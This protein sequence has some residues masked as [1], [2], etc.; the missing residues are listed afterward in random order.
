MAKKLPA[1]NLWRERE[2]VDWNVTT[3]H[4]YL[5]EM[6]EARY[7][8]PKYIPFRNWSCEKG[9]LKRFMD[10][11]GN[12]IT[13]EFIDV[14]LRNYKEK[15]DYPT[16]TFGFAYS[17]MQNPHLTKI[18]QKKAQA[19]QVEDAQTKPTITVSENELADWF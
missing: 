17:Y 2:L 5:M 10:E 19:K 14:C 4:A 18:L 15:P 1:A 11:H 16:L 6:C 7:G 13:K 3:F 9:M 8:V 12:E